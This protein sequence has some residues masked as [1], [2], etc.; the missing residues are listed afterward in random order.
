MYIN[1]VYLHI[2]SSRHL[3]ALQRADAQIIIESLRSCILRAARIKRSG[4]IALC[5]SCINPIWK[6]THQGFHPPHPYSMHFAI[7]PTWLD[8]MMGHPCSCLV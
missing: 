6:C 7:G 1:D 3:H 5:R 4:F 2:L 8:L